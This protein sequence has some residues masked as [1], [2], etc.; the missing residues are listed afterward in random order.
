MNKKLRQKAIIEYVESVA[1]VSIHELVRLTESSIATI[2]RDLLELHEQ[3]KLIRTPGGARNI[4]QQ[5]QSLVLRTFDQRRSHNAEAKLAI[6]AAAR[7]LVQPGL[8]IAID[9]GT[10]CWQFAT[11][12]TDIAPLRVITSAVAVIEALGDCEGIELV[13][14]GGVFRKNNLDFTGVRTVTAFQQFAVDMAF[15]GC[16]GF[17]AEGGIYTD[18][19]ESHAISRAIAESAEVRVVLFDRQKVGK[20][21]CCRILSPAEI[22]CIITDARLELPAG[23][24]CQY[25]HAF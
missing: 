3:N 16:D 18:D 24:R 10:T 15:L 19:M 6:A 17:I 14:I 22:D 20:R 8:T 2:R 25:I 7:K 12:L 11:L 4:V 5:Q 1:E 9:S 23:S 13:V 21:H